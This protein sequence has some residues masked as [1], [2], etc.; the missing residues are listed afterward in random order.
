MPLTKFVR[1][2]KSGD[3]IDGR[4]IDPA[5][6]DQMAASYNPATYGARIW[7][8]H[9]R[10]YLPSGDFRAYGD[11]V[12]VKAETDPD[13]SKVLLAQLA[14]TPDLVKVWADRQKVY[15]SIE[16]D[17]NFANSGSAYLVGLA[18]TDSPAS[19][20][21]EMLTYAVKSDLAPAQVKT[22]LFSP[23]V[24]APA[25]AESETAE[26][27]TDILGRLRDVLFGIKPGTTTTTTTGT[28]TGTGT[29]TPAATAESQDTAAT[30]DSQAAFAAI[31]Q[32]LE[33]LAAATSSTQTP[34][35]VDTSLADQLR[36]LS[37]DVAAL[38]KLAR[39]TTDATRHSGAGAHATIQT[40]C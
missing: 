10:S 9:L 36:R 8:E 19:L 33:K 12:A 20:G 6:I 29:G 7:M 31:A 24:E 28:G 17:P 39:T 5:H 18:V 16:I 40:D 21:T 4:K 25:P 26:T 3:T 11:V 23:L 34:P 15:F 35:T 30:A 13:G 27:A 2:A 37:D 22:H 38:N 1:V 14:P 32:A